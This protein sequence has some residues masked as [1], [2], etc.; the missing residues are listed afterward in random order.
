MPPFRKKLRIEYH[1]SVEGDTEKWY[2]LRLQQ[3]VNEKSEIQV[4]FDVDSRSNPVKFVKKFKATDNNMIIYHICDM[5]NQNG[6]N[7]EKFK[8]ILAHLKEASKLKAD[9]KY[10]LGYSNISFEL[11]T[12]LHKIEYTKSLTLCSQYFQPI[13]ECF[14]GNFENLHAYKEEVNFKMCLE[15]LTLDD[16]RSAIKRA[17]QIQKSCEDSGYREKEHCGY[18]YYLENPSLSIHQIIKK[19]LKDANVL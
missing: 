2:L 13:K 6:F 19:I 9:V 4:V 10:K 14:Q 18:R 16:V 15:K 12:I 5:E 11:W 3:L 17:E 7:E 8:K 1:F